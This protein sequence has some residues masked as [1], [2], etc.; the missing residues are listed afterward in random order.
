MAP[1]PRCVV[2]IDGI[3]IYAG[4]YRVSKTLSSKFGTLLNFLLLKEIPVHALQIQ[5]F[6]LKNTG[7]TLFI[8]AV[9]CGILSLEAPL[10]S[11][12][13]QQAPQDPKSWTEK[14]SPQTNRGD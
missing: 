13:F 14:P 8:S 12:R 6:L 2:G 3:E 1:P 7:F 9:A 11:F 4:F 5:H 10:A